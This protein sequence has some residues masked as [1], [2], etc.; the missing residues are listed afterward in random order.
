MK[1]IKG[2]VVADFLADF[3]VEDPN[4]DLRL[5]EE[6]LE[7]PPTPE[8]EVLPVNGESSP[9]TLGVWKIYVDGASNERGGED[10]A[11]IITSETI[12]IEF[13]YILA[14]NTTN[15]EAEYETLIHGLL[16]AKSLQLIEFILYTD[17]QLTAKK[18]GG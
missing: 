18:V 9:K 1:A 11:V 15:N 8:P 5:C 3:P 16:D 14:F 12:F 7:T 2:K 13:S 17:S 10:G 6:H 4:S